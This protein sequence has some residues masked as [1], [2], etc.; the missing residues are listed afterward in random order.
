MLFAQ[1]AQIEFCNGLT[2]LLLKEVEPARD[3][4]KTSTMRRPMISSRGI[5]AISII[6][7]TC[8]LAAN[9][10]LAPAPTGP[11]R[12]TGRENSAVGTAE[13]GIHQAAENSSEMDRSRLYASMESVISSMN[14]KQSLL[15]V[16]VRGKD[17]FE[18]YRIPGSIRVPLHALKTKAF[19][20][21]RWVVLVN[22]GYPNPVLERICWDMRSAGFAHVSIL[23]GGLRGWQQ[24]NGPI[25]GEAFA[26][27]DASRMSPI[28]FFPHHDSTEWLVVRAVASASGPGRFR[29]LV[30]SAIDLPW[31]GNPSKF[32]TALK[33]LVARESRS[34]LACILVC[35][36]GGTQYE[37][38]ERAVRQ[39]GI[40]TVFY[41]KGGMEA[42]ETFVEQQ[43]LLQQRGTEE[44]ERCATCS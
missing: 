4:R 43:A 32:A 2:T 10:F 20:K 19:L 29:T 17:A 21:D 14:R 1:I 7:G 39:E 41:L 16:D 30:P 44:M 5:L 12:S 38:I 31:E 35:D 27:I 28:D 24:Q 22:E 40:S 9:L 23:N 37:R 42:Y 26:A 33:A 3:R 15:L 11:L 6:S 25:E 36:A 18:K 8:L 34:P 13:E